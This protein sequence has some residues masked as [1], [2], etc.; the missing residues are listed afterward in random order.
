MRQPL[1]R[2]IRLLDGPQ[3]RLAREAM[4]EDFDSP[5]RTKNP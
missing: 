2:L 5:G 1:D 4:G 3:Q